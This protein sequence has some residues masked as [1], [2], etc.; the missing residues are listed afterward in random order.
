MLGVLAGLV[1]G[2][3]ELFLGNVKLCHK[4]TEKLVDQLFEALK[5]TS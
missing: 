4:L 3:E 1:T 5:N 2:L